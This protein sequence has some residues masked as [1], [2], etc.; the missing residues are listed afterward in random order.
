[1]AR[2]CQK[3]YTCPR[4]AIFLAGY[5]S[6]TRIRVTFNSGPIMWLRSR[7]L[8]FCGGIESL[9]LKASAGA[10]GLVGV[11]IGAVGGGPSV[12]AVLS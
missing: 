3:S 7:Q 9:P 6:V 5:L 2:H 11:D 8:V 4:V 1:M 12:V 10:G